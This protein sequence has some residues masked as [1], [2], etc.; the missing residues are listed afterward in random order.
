MSQTMLGDILEL[1]QRMSA[2]ETKL[3]D[4]EARIEALES[5]ATLPA[6]EEKRRRA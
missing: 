3:Q 6:A 1:M 4:A 5:A 2:L